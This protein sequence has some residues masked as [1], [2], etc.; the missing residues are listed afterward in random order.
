MPSFGAG[1]IS[2][3]PEENSQRS[4]AK[5]DVVVFGLQIDPAAARSLTTAAPRCRKPDCEVIGFEVELGPAADRS[6]CQPEL[7][8]IF[9]E[10]EL[11]SEINLFPRDPK[12]HVIRI[13]IEPVQSPIV[14]PSSPT[15]LAYP[16]TPLQCRIRCKESKDYL[17]PRAKM[18]SIFSGGTEDI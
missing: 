13:N 10:E 6:P 17:L 4:S 18:L 7:D 12:C 14:D 11:G 8:G 1:T 15:A 2:S 16:M 9:I 3:T 5:P